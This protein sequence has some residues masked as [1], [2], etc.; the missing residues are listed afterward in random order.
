M[1]QVSCLPARFDEEHMLAPS[2]SL[3]LNHQQ[4]PNKRERPLLPHF[5]ISTVV[6]VPWPSHIA[7]VTATISSLLHFDICLPSTLIKT[8]FATVRGIHSLSSLGTGIVFIGPPTTR[9]E[10]WSKKPDLHWPLLDRWK[11]RSTDIVPSISHRGAEFSG[12]HHSSIWKRVMKV[13]TSS[14]Q[15]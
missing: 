10:V 3:R 4:T 15:P 8:A 5:Q 6:S 7:A 2:L 13:F 9:Q 12:H 14:Y 1:R 11:R